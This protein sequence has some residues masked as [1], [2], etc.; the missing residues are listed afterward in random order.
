MPVL[1]WIVLFR[2][3]GPLHEVLFFLMI[4]QENFELAK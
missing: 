2:N 4:L 1:K 3:S